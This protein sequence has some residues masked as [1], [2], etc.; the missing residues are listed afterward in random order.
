[1]NTIKIARGD[2]AGR[3]Q[4]CLMSPANL[5]SL[6]NGRKA[7]LALFVEGP[8]AQSREQAL[9][10]LLEKMESMMGRMWKGTAEGGTISR[11]QMFL[12]SIEE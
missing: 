8:P 3:Y 2:E 9:H 11:E 6:A 7:A 1:M 4:A 5:I 12:R 10:N